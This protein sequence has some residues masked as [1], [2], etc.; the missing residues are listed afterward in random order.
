MIPTNISDLTNDSGFITAI[1]GEYITE[2]ELNNK[3]Y[4]TTAYVNTKISEAQLGGGSGCS[5]GVVETT[6]TTSS[7][8]FNSDGSLDSN[9]SFTHIDTYVNFES[10]SGGTIIAGTSGWWMFIYYDADKNYIGSYNPSSV[11]TDYSISDI[12]SQKSDAVYFR[13]SIN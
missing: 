8:G 3:N 10:V 4:A 6:V 5:G 2:T 1:P 11:N 7:C 12:H 9:S 13:A